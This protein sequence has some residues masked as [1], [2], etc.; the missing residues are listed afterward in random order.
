[1]I[2]PPFKKKIYEIFMNSA[3]IT[4]CLLCG[5]VFGLDFTIISLGLLI[6]IKTR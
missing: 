6:L 4:F 2:N 1:M 3:A 5:S